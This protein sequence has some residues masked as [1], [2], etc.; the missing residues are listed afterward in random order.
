[1]FSLFRQKKES[2]TFGGKE[3]LGMYAVGSREIV[4]KE[5]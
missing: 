4:G 1:M 3:A 5:C 2:H